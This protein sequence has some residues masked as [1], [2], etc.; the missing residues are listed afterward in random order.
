[1]NKHNKILIVILVALAALFLVIK[2]TKDPK[3]KRVKFF[4]VSPESVYGVEF[5]FK[6]DT[7]KVVKDDHTWTLEKP[8]ISEVNYNKIETLF[9]EALP[10]ETSSIPVSVSTESLEQYSL[11]EKGR[12]S[13]TLFSRDKK[14]IFKAYLGRVGGVSYGKE[15]DDNNVYL[16]SKNIVNLLQ[17][18]LFLWRSLN[19]ISIPKQEIHSI[20]VDYS[21]NSYTLTSS[22]TLWTYTDSETSFEVRDL[23]PALIKIIQAIGEMPATLN[24]DYEFEIHEET[25]AKPQLVLTIEKKDKKVVTLKFA[26]EVGEEDFF[27]VQKDD[28]T[29]HLYSSDKDMVNLFTVS[30][31]RFKQ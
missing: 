30:S 22:D 14:E 10:V 4:K 15:I 13:M 7:L 3:E 19:I 12:V 25:L 24:Y 28:D 20:S 1:M 11:D 8:F 2:L 9:E 23:N 27:V 17:P 26:I 5:I 21:L 6:G 29:D 16:L 18:E 31:E